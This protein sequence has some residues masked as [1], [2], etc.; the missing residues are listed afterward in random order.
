MLSQL[1][2]KN[3]SRI[4]PRPFLYSPLP[5]ISTM[6]LLL[7][8]DLSLYL[9]IYLSLSVAQGM[10]AG[11]G[12]PGTSAAAGANQGRSR[13]GA[14]GAGQGRGWLGGP[15]RRGAASSRRFALA[16]G[17]EGGRQVALPRQ[18][19]LA[20]ECGREAAL[21]QWRAQVAEW[22]RI[23]MFWIAAGVGH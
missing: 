9:S 4:S 21:P 15:Q 18:L 22:Q 3:L 11:L 8:F 5:L 23:S 13:L 17:A 2:E 12:A 10:V 19:A 7:S 14:P 16:V 20:T 6:Y 1:L